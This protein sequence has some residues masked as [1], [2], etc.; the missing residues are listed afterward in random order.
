MCASLR[1]VTNSSAPNPK[2]TAAFGLTI[3]STTPARSNFLL[4]SVRSGPTSAPTRPARRRGWH[5]EQLPANRAC[6]RAAS[7][8]RPVTSA[9]VMRG[10]PPGRWKKP[11]AAVRTLRS[12]LLKMTEPIASR[13]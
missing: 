2:A 3:A 6:P 8:A 1:R 7:P 11:A 12:G 13:S 5:V 9:T 10:A 4:M